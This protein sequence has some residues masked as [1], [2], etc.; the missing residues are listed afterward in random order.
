MAIHTLSALL[1]TFQVEL[2]VPPAS[3]AHG[4]GHPMTR[5]ALVDTGSTITAISPAVKGALNPSPLGKALYHPR[6]QN[7]IW[8]DTYLVILEIEPHTH[9]SRTFALEVIEEQPVTPGVDVLLGHNLLGRVVMV[10]DGPR[11]R[12]I[13]TY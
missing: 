9:P 3:I 6:G 13:L 2:R 11:D 8:I 12:L 4:G 1:P 10:W 5:I 7:P